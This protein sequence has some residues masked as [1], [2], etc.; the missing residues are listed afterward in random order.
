MLKWSPFVLWVIVAGCNGKDSPAPV[1]APPEEVASDLSFTEPKPVPN[2]VRLRLNPKPGISFT[3]ILSG[4]IEVGPTPGKASI[5][6]GAAGKSKITMDYTMRVVSSD[7]G[8]VTV[9]FSSTPLKMV[10]KAQGAWEQLGAK[11]AE[12]RFD[13]RAGLLEDP[14][15]LFEGLFGTGMM[16][17]PES[18]IG[19]GSTW[20][21]ENTRDMPPFG[22]VMIKETFIYK[23]TETRNGL[24]V[25]RIDSRASGSLEG[26]QMHATYLIRDDGMPYS[27]TIDSSASSP[28]AVNQ[29]GTKVWANFHVV[30]R[31]SPK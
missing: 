31:T 15:S 21:S 1:A 10:G 3:Q 18:P 27:A 2:G 6:T 22:P 13:R 28:I 14:K 30:V 4:T 8:S 16:M 26:M 9:A 23:G 7:A 24:K 29:D 17:F 5:P 20:S 12:M 11:A 25:H 19:P